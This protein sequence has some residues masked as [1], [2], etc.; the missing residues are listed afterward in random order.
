M[1]VIVARL[2]VLCLSLVVISS[3]LIGQSVVAEVD[4]ADAVGVWLFDEG[5]GEIAKDSSGNDHDGE[6]QGDLN[7]VAGKFGGALEFPGQEDSFVNI[8]HE[9]SLNLTEW[10]IV[11]WVKLGEPPEGFHTI[12]YKNKPEQVRNY[13]MGVSATGLR[14]DL[15]KGDTRTSAQ[16]TAPIL[17]DKWHHVA[18]TYDGSFVRSYTDGVLGAE[19]GFEG[20]PQTNSGPVTIGTHGATEKDT[21]WPTKGILDEVC[22]LN[23]ALTEDQ[24]KSIMTEGLKALG[25]APVE[26]ENKL[27]TTW[28]CMKAS[29]CY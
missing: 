20:P 22:I 7:W 1:K 21:L 18:G 17:D 28:G 23:V 5:T 12:I 4:P 14:V 3:M 6:I 9:D 10:T 24:I 16:G 8:P 2:T 15:S 29:A 25:L 13:G 11:A 27:S 19:T 26:P